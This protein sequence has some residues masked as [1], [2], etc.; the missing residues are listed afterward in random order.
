[1]P[2][3]VAQNLRVVPPPYTGLPVRDERGLDARIPAGSRLEWTLRFAP[4]PDQPRLGLLAGPPLP[5]RRAGEDWV[6]ERQVDGAFLYR[7]D[8]GDPRAPRPPLHR[9]DVIPDAPPQV[10]VISPA[11][12]LTPVRPGQ[13]SWS[14][15]FA[16]TDDYGVAAQA[17]LRI[18]LA[19]GEGENVT[20][21]EREIAL[22][23][24]GPARD[25]RFAPTLDFARLH[26]RLEL[27]GVIDIF[28]KV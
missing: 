19:V 2:R 8:P 24:S 3:L 5:L 21:S 17:R 6:A 28:K 22:A 18:T 25:R 16:A 1:M 20:F 9:I 14:P 13:R 7:V 23:G 15:V 26:H 12:S 11:T 4:M 10:R 27:V